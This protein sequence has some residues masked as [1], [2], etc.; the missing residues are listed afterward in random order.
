VLVAGLLGACSSSGSTTSSSSSA[1]SSTAAKLYVSVGDSYASGYQPGAGNNRNGFAYQLVDKLHAAGTDLQLANFGC[2]G[3]T[4]T[5]ILQE[6]GCNALGPDGIDYPDRSQAVAAEDY[7]RQHR[8]DVALITVSIGGNDI[9]RC[10][11]AADPVGC[12]TTAVDGIKQNLGTL[13]HDV[14]DAAGPDA[15]IVGITYPD[16]ALGA[17]V[18][19][20]PTAQN[21]AKLSVVAFQSLLNPALKAAYES[22]GGTFVDVTAATGAYGSFDEST[23]VDP[24]GTVPVPVAKVCQLT[25][26]CDQQDIHPKT[27]GYALIADLIAAVVAHR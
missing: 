10:A 2:A 15:Q 23:T 4:T 14:R 12:I 24:Y 3:A 19:G 18:I 27:E 22:V 16:V 11:T 26:F 21:I 8:G 7:L 1:R 17:W 6:T 9:T 5:S 25:Y 20:D 13:V